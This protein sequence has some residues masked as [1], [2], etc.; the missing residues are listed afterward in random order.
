MNPKGSD[1]FRG[2]PH[3]PGAR[4]DQRR[5]PGRPVSSCAATRLRIPPAPVGKRRLR[6]PERGESDRARWIASAGLWHPR[7]RPECSYRGKTWPKNRTRLSALVEL[8]PAPGA[9][10]CVHAEALKRTLQISQI[11]GIPVG[12][13]V[14]LRQLSEIVSDKTGQRGI[15]FGCK[16]A[17]FSNDFVLEGESYV[18]FHM[19]RGSLITC[20][21]P[22]VCPSL[23]ICEDGDSCINSHCS[24]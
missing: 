22:F 4:R 23:Q 2:T 19:L 5:K 17:N 14:S 3:H 15:P 11:T 7:H 21:G 10:R 18:H 9:G 1:G 13:L 24:G 16:T 6:Q 20:Q 8:A 12:G